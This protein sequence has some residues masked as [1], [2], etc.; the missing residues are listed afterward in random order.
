MTS[1]IQPLLI[2][3]AATVQSALAQLQTTAKGILLLVDAEGRLLRTVTDGDLRRLLLA[4]SPLE[5]ALAVLPPQPPRCVEVGVE[6]MR[7]LAAMNE[8]RV[9]QLPVIDADGRPQALLLRRELGSEILLS[10]P[11]LGDQEMGFIAEAIRSNWV[12]PLG[13]NVDAFEAELAGHVGIG[14]AAAVSSGTAAIH[15]A[16]RLLEVGPGDSVFCSTLTFVG[17][18]NPIL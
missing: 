14:H 18:A 16:L 7:A 3:A 4:G 15:L 11:H 6:R 10:T 2:T 9:D 13:P 12:A 5:A 17:S 1:S 8:F